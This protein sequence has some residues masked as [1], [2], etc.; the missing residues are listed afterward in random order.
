MLEK[1]QSVGKLRKVTLILLKVYFVLVILLGLYFIYQDK[2]RNIITIFE[3]KNGNR[4]FNI[5]TIIYSSI[6][7]IAFI[8]ASILGSVIC[9]ISLQRKKTF[10]LRKIVTIHSTTI[11][12]YCGWWLT[13]IQA[14]LRLANVGYSEIEIW[15]FQLLSKVLFNDA[16]L[17]MKFIFLLSGLGLIMM[18]LVANKIELKNEHLN[19]EPEK[20]EA[21]T[22]SMQ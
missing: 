14:V 21:V 18:H 11:F 17:V 9:L 15:N 5:E 22:E 16:K 19:I 10:E 7:E 20:I 8:G 12:L 6:W 2:G 1:Q 4:A 13:L 3:Y